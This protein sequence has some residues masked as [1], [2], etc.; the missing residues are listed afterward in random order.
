MFG[1]I[2]GLFGLRGAFVGRA[3]LTGCVPEAEGRADAGC[4]G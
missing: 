4:C 2:G 3:E 1:R